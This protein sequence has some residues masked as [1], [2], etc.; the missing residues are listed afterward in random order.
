MDVAF[1]ETDA[2]IFMSKQSRSKAENEAVGAGQED[3]SPFAYLSTLS[4]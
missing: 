2:E 1:Q 4:G 3:K